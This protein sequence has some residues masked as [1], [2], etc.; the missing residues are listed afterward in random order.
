MEKNELEKKWDALKVK[1]PSEYA[2]WLNCN[3]ELDSL[4]TALA[5]GSISPA[6][7]ES[8]KT[9]LDVSVFMIELAVGID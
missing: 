6:D 8:K 1:H 4:E 9:T 5:D 7:Y 2:E 3:K